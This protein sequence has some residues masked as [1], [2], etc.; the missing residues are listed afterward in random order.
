M[1]LIFLDL[2]ICAICGNVLRKEEGIVAFPP[3]EGNQQDPMY[4][5][6]DAGFHAACFLTHP[7]KDEVACAVEAYRARLKLPRP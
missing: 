2:S 4:F 1:A 5:F 3:F 6:S 7:L